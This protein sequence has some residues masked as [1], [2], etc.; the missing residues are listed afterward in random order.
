MSGRGGLVKLRAMST[1]SA[2]VKTRFAPSPSGRLHL[3]NAR[4][5]LFNFL[6]AHR[7]GGIF[8]LRVED[9]DAER[10][11]DEHLHALL[12]D[13]Q[14]LG[15]QWDEGPGRDGG[16]GPYRQSERYGLYDELYERLRRDGHLYP[17]FCSRERLAASRK[18]QLAAGH[19]PRYDGTCARLSEAERR[20]RLDRGEPHT[21]RF[22][23]PGGRSIRFHDGVRGDQHF[24]S[25]EIGD[26]VVRRANGAPAFFFCNAVD[27]ALMGVTHVLRGE[28]HLSNTPRQLLVLQALDLPAPDY[29]HLP[30]L[31]DE[32]GGP[33]SKRAGSLGASRL[34]AEGVL[35]PA[36]CNYLARLGHHMDSDALM[37]LPALAQ[38]FELERVGKSPA[39]YDAAQLAAWQRRAVD[40]MDADA[41]ARWVPEAALAP[42]PP[43]SRTAFLEA[44]RPN[45]VSP[46]E[47]ADWARALFG[48]WLPPEDEHELL[49]GA[50]AG[51]F[52]A[53]LRAYEAH[54]D[55]PGAFLAA[56]KQQAG[57]SGRKLFMPLRV[58]LT[59][60]SHGP[61]IKSL[62]GLLPASRV[63]ERLNACR[64][65]AQHA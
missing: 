37:S 31:L 13:L 52:E 22:H 20:Q 49:R 55:E 14:W 16:A 15:L 36:L 7:A 19:P 38:A 65:L 8:L 26:F 10:S 28:D 42:V 63:R 35:A 33:L 34:R 25:A 56:L 50:G 54:G 1:S 18:R 41:M 45:V 47:V 17:C 6:F 32:D 2:R 24:A 23:V 5:A 39:R 57:V 40:A 9:T 11:E 51:Y 3:G 64:R 60:R 4:T 21:L 30:L 62:L 58:A 46:D 12:A 61:D 44:V 53:A 48:T 43:Q 27:D 29:A 59:G